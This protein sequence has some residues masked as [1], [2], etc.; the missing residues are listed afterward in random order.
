[1]FLKDYGLRSLSDLKSFIELNKHLP[2]IPPAS[3]IEKNG[4][5]L[6]DMQKRLTQKVEELT[7]YILQLKEEIDL[8]K[9]KK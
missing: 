9:L 8:L 7:L 6:G 4:L 2:D 3:E 1:M 5:E